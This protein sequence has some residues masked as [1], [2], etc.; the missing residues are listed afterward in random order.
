[1]TVQPLGEAWEEPRAEDS[2]QFAYSTLRDRIL[3]GH[4]EAGAVL[5]QVRLARELGISRTP[6][7]EALRRLVAEHLVTGDFNHR[8]RVSELNLD[9]FDQ[10]YAMRIA[11]EPLG[12]AATLPL[13]GDERRAA[14]TRSVERMEEA[15][16]ALDLTWFRA[17]H[18]AFHL[19]LLDGGGRRTVTLLEDLWDQSERYRLA[20]LHRDHDHAGG[21][22]T[23][24][25]RL[26][27]SQDEH[28]AI[29]AAAL[30]GDVG[31]CIAAVVAHLQRTVE[32]VFR[33]S[34]R[35]PRP[36]MVTMAVQ[37]R[38]GAAG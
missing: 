8:M 1:M 34:M 28:R 3:A 5:S 10:I 15:I 14:L 22:G 26:R 29:L 25:E 24:M 27:T 30:D 19:G 35:V 36:T 32:V 7:R 16:G 23:S 12:I 2:M 21:V 37:A 6:L 9:D 38:S 11:L 4:L 20:Y 31:G 13:L 17:E 18:R 33:E